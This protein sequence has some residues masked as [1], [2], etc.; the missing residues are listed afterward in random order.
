MKIT[1]ENEKMIKFLQDLVK[2][3]STNTYAPN[4]SWKIDEPIEKGINAVAKMAKILLA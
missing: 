1:K 4:E 3:N 2:I